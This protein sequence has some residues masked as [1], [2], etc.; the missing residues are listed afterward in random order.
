MIFAPRFER[1]IALASS[2]LARAALSLIL[3]SSAIVAG[4]GDAAASSGPASAPGKPIFS[5]LLSGSSTVHIATDPEQNIVVAGSFE[6]TLDLGAVRLISEDE[7]DIFIAKLDHE[8][9]LLWAERVGG[10]GTQHGL[11]VATD[12]LGNVIVTGSSRAAVTAGSPSPSSQIFAAKLDA[13]GQTVWMNTF[14]PMHEGI[15]LGAAVNEKGDVT[16]VGRLS[17]VLWSDDFS[18]KSSQDTPNGDAFVL[19]LAPNGRVLWGRALGGLGEQY[20]GAV[21]ATPGGGVVVSGLFSGVLDIDGQQHTSTARPSAF[22][23]AFD[24][25][26]CVRFSQNFGPSLTD[27]PRVAADPSGDIVVAGT[28]QRRIEIGG[29]T[30]ISA[31]EDDVFAVKLDELGAPIFVRSFGDRTSQQLGGLAVDAKGEVVLAMSSLGNVDLGAGPIEGHG[32]YD[33]ALAR[34]DALG[35]PLWGQV[36]GDH[37]DQLASEIA[38]DAAGNIVLTG[39]LAGSIDFGGGALQSTSGFD[40]FLGSLQP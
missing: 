2:R 7:S 1:A 19:R 37:Q 28:F 22:V 3:S 36:F 24:N 31:G 5:A 13:S 18:L 12:P 17:G 16:I 33:L 27:I 38:I 15:G 39:Q 34:L 9:A 30:R 21:A 14:G 32:G 6:G 10:A 35:D 25:D 20:A 8:G 29:E 23:A 26:G 4:A 11:A 40:A